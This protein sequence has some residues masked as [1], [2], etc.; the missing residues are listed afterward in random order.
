MI[1][2]FEKIGIM[3]KIFEKI[4]VMVKIFQ[5][6]GIMIKIL[7]LFCRFSKYYESNPERLTYNGPCNFRLR[8]A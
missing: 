3:I 6:I 7:E 4:G 2:I 8:P 5:K 1:Q